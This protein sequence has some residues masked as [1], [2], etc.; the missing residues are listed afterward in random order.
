[1]QKERSIS[2]NRKCFNVRNHLSKNLISLLFIYTSNFHYLSLF[3]TLVHVLQHSI[4]KPPRTL[5]ETSVS[6]DFHSIRIFLHFTMSI[7]FLVGDKTPKKN[8]I[9]E[10]ARNHIS[11]YHFPVFNLNCT[12]KFKR[13][14][15]Y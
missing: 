15:Y 5:D 8:E 11:I 4:Q 7:L 10:N 2:L 9:T 6:N 13:I 1:M 14:V 3:S 12:Q